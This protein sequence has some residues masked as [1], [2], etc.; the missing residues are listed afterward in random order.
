MLNN[1]GM[2]LEKFQANSN[3]LKSLQNSTL[4]VKSLL[5]RSFLEAM[6]FELTLTLK[7]LNSQPTWLGRKLSSTKRRAFL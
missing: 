6:L 5:K 2:I 1:S 3:S 4:V 7:H